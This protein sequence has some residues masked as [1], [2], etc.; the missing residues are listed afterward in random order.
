MSVYPQRPP[1][2]A[3]RLCRLLAKTC[4][5]NEIGTDAFTLVVNVVMTEDAKR[6]TGAVTFTNEQ[7]MPICGFGGR[8]RLNNARTKA[9]RAGWIHYEPGRKGIP[10]RYWAT[11]PEQYREIRDGSCDGV[12]VPDQDGNHAC[13][14]ETGRKPG[15]KPGRQ[16]DGN[17]DGNTAPFLPIPIPKPK[18]GAASGESPSGSKNGK[19]KTPKFDPLSIKVPPPLRTDRFRGAWRDW[20][21]HRREIKKPLTPT[22]TTQQIRRLAEWGESR[23]V[24]AINHTVA[25]GWTGLRE[26]D[27]PRNG[28]P[29]NGSP[30]TD[31]R[32]LAEQLRRNRKEGPK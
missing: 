32:A 12:S 9:M 23:A 10:G 27:V 25:M 14:P 8:D 29:A 15:R 31:L 26:P 4:A 5:A 1:M 2:F 13:R 21:Q 22:A 30:D 7:L 24:A 6:Y 20:C 16:A 11:I 28:S 19:A 3:N 18:E 17:Q